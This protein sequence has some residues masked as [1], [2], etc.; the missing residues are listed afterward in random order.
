M[1]KLKEPCFSTQHQAAVL[2][3]ICEISPDTIIYKREMSLKMEKQQLW[4]RF[5]G[6]LD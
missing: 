1:I 6:R 2:P 3:I 4:R 5:I